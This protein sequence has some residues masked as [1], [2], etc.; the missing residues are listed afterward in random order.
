MRIRLRFTKTGKIR[1]TSHRDLARVWER[2][3]RRVGLPV[4]LSSRRTAPVGVGA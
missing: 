4:A 2:V 1:W 3:I